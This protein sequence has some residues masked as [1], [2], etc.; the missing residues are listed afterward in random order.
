MPEGMLA[1]CL[2]VLLGSVSN[3]AHE[4]AYAFWLDFQGEFPVQHGRYNAI[5]ERVTDT[6]SAHSTPPSQ[7]TGTS[8]V[9][10]SATPKPRNLVSDALTSPARKKLSPNGDS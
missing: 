9:D 10:S 8:G 4:S 2:Q 1:N 3:M 5:K 7:P 6:N